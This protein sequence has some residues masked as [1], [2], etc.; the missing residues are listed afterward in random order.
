[1]K[2]V[3]DKFGC[4]G[5]LVVATAVSLFVGALLGLAWFSIHV[6]HWGHW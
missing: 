4:V 3:E 2:A 6:L 1:M 5:M